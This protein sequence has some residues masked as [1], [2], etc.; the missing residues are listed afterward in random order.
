MKS[1]KLTVLL[2]TYN[3]GKYIDKAL[4]SILAQKTNFD[5]KIHI[6]NDKSTDNTTQIANEYTIKHP[7]KIIHKLREENLGVVGNIFDGIKNVETEYYA[8]L[9]GD[10]Y[11]SD[12]NKLQ[13]QVDALDENPDCTLCG[14]NTIAK[15]ND[16][17]EKLLFTDKKH[18]IKEKYSFPKKLVKKDFVK[19]HPSSRVFRTSAIDFDNLKDVSTVVWDSC[20]YWYFLEKGNMFFIN[21]PMSVYNFTEEGI[22]SGSSKKKQKVMALKN[23]FAINKEFNFKYNRLFLPLL[24]KYKKDFKLSF[25]ERLEARFK[26]ATLGEK[27]D[28]IITRLKL[29]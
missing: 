3:H 17:S 27:Y 23:I 15:Y 12:V 26:P 25:K 1:K 11:W 2:V 29:D 6:L 13:E 9:E 19:V 20:A 14:H 5:F 24:L 8:L 7:E 4:D 22:F 28:E 16:G 21:K 10:D 18:N